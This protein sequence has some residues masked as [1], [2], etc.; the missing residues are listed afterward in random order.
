MN[1]IKCVLVIWKSYHN[2]HYLY[3]FLFTIHYWLLWL[4]DGFWVIFTASIFL[5]CLF[6]LDFLL[7]KVDWDLHIRTFKMGQKSHIFT[8]YVT[9]ILRLMEFVVLVNINIF[10][11]SSF[12]M[13]LTPGVC[14]FANNLFI[15]LRNI[16]YLLFK[17]DFLH[18]V[19]PF[20]YILLETHLLKQSFF[21]NFAVS[22]HHQT[23]ILYFLFF[24]D[25]SNCP[26][27]YS[28]YVRLINIFIL[29]LSLQHH[30]G[31]P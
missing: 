26:S 28:S 20:I 5:T 7:N 18:N 11:K 14:G 12:L 27:F 3:F 31:F 30:R 24:Q 22:P 23:T 1:I 2:Y 25:L 10:S 17:L 13:L 15:N 6:P 21:S 8:I 16:S 29:I 4:L 19:L 9:S